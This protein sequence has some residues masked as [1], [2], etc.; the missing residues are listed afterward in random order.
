[1]RKINTQAADI[2]VKAA[3]YIRR[4]GWQ[5]TGMS[6]HGAPRCS[7]G[8]LE[9]ASPNKLWNNQLAKLMYDSLYKELRGINLTEFNHQ[10]KSGLEVARLFENTAKSIRSV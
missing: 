10:A 4:Y 8:A 7:M 2:F 1:M 3:Q 5:E 6:S 9:S